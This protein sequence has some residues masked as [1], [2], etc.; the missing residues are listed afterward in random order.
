MKKMPKFT[1]MEYT[2]STNNL[3]NY[4]LLSSNSYNYGT[5]AKTPSPTSFPTLMEDGILV[6]YET[7]NFCSEVI[8][9]KE[10]EE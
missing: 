10:I 8:E 6:K 3:M 7:P 5:L 1:A 2:T 4:E 9:E